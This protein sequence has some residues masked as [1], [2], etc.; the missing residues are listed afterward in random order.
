MSFLESS[1]NFHEHLD[2]LTLRISKQVALP[3]GPSG[4]V[5]RHLKETADPYGASRGILSAYP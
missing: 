5:T 3:V 2:S 1:L 4:H